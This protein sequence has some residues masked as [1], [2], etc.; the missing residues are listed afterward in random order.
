VAAS[1]RFTPDF[2]IVRRLLTSPPPG[3]SSE[4]LG[5]LIKKTI[6]NPALTLPLVL[7]A[8]Y[9]KQGSDLAILH[10]TAF[11]RL[12]LALAL[13]LIRYANNWLSQKSLDN[14]KSDKYIWSQEIVLVTGGAGGIGGSV[15]RMLAE[16]G[17]KVVVLDVIPMTYKTS[18]LPTALIIFRATWPQG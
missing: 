18:T 9:T 1:P 10:E 13:G 8:R 15:V 4:V 12:Q 6:L 14:W 17:I 11:S 5:S 16:K 3:F 2:K 7:L